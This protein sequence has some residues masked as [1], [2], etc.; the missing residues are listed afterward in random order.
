MLKPADSNESSLK[1]HTS[2]S[3]I[4]RALYSPIAGLPSPSRQKYPEKGKTYQCYQP[5]LQ[6]CHFDST[7]WEK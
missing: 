7:F 1:D 4:P 3:N 6:T 5:Q 2:D